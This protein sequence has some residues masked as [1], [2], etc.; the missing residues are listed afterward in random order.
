[1]LQSLFY[2]LSTNLPIQYIAKKLFDINERKKY[3]DPSTLSGDALAAQDE[4]LF[5]TARLVN[6]GWFGTGSDSR[7]LSPVVIL[8]FF[9]RQSSF[10][11]MSPV[12]WVW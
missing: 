3:K 11:I 9:V 2:N 4:E 6:C 5:Q 12:F 8:M 7:M 1:M 10:L